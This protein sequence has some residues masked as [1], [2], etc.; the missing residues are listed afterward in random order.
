ME[1]GGEVTSGNAYL[2]LYPTQF[3][4]AVEHVVEMLAVLIHVI[5]SVR[6]ISLFRARVPA[7]ASAAFARFCV[8][9]ARSSLSILSALHE[10]P[11]ANHRRRLCSHQ[12]TLSKTP[13]RDRTHRP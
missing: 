9:D 13:T 7:P 2:A 8:C 5:T 4:L 11:L 12:Q 6:A 3:L 1:R 10:P